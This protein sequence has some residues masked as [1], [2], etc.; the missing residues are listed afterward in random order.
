MVR[1]PG[2]AWCVC[3][4][5]VLL[6]RQNPA[7]NGHGAG[8]MADHALCPPESVPEDWASPLDLVILRMGRLGTIRYPSEGKEGGGAWAGLGLAWG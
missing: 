5:M 3:A 8:Q 1:V 6:T 7:G 4:R 2:G